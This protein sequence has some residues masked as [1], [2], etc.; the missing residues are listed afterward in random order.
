MFFLG[1]AYVLD[2]NEEY[3]M[4]FPSAYGRYVQV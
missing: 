3:S 1:K 2:H 4:T